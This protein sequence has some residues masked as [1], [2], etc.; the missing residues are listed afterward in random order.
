[1]RLRA[2]IAGCGG[3]LAGAAAGLSP[4][5]AQ[6]WAPDAWRDAASETLKLDAQAPFTARADAAFGPAVEL[7]ADFRPAGAAEATDRRDVWLEHEGFTDR[8]SLSTRGRLRRADGA[9]LPVTPMDEAELDRTGYDVRYVRGWSGART[10]TASGLE[11]SLTPHAGIGLGSRGGSAEAGAT[12]RVG[13]GLKKLMPDGDKVFGERSRWF[14][15]A[16][17]SGRAVGYNFA[18]TRDGDYARSGYSRDEGAFLGDASIGV[19]YRR[20]A[21]QGSLGVVYREIETEG[22]NFGPDVDTDVDEGLIA[23]QFSIRPN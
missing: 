14:V 23:F 19:A 17:G 16:A 13:S 10:R 4:V 12:L 22:V 1:M 18:R 9:P 5:Q 2:W 20:G 3:V 15:Y 6:T 8:V 11:V 7:T 21:M